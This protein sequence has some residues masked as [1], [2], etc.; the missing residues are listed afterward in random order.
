MGEGR[1]IFF[2]IPTQKQAQH[3][4]CTTGNPKSITKNQPARH[5]GPSFFGTSLFFRCWCHFWNFCLGVFW[6]KKPPLSTLKLTIRASENLAEIAPNRKPDRL[7]LAR[8][9]SGASCLTLRVYAKNMLHSAPKT[10]RNDAQKLL[11]PSK[12]WTKTFCCFF[13]Q[14][15]GLEL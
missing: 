15:E 2:P 10:W 4:H 11:W 1:T 9:F 13:F 6:W 5:L 14:V 3:M 7:R 12:V 8:I